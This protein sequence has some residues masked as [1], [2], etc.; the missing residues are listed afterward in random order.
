MTLK[1]Q[2][3]ALNEWGRKATPLKIQ[4]EFGYM[5]KFSTITKTNKNKPKLG[6]IL[7]RKDTRVLTQEYERIFDAL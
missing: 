3:I 1:E 2:E 7:R 6:S 5:H 4:A